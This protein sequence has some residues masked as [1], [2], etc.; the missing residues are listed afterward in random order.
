MRTKCKNQASLFMNNTP[1]SI[2][3]ATMLLRLP[4]KDEPWDSVLQWQYPDTSY[5]PERKT[6]AKRTLASPLPQVNFGQVEW[7][8]RAI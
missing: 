6:M 2:A 7:E 8:V 1:K 4:P 3:R 5:K